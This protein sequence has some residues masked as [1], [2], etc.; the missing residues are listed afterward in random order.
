M[1]ESFVF[2]LFDIHCYEKNK[3][4][5]YNNEN[6]YFSYFMIN[7]SPRERQSKTKK[8]CW[9]VRKGKIL[10]YDPSRNKNI[11]GQTKDF[12]I[13]YICLFI[14]R[15]IVAFCS[16]KKV[17]CWYVES[18]GWEAQCSTWFYVYFWSDTSLRDKRSDAFQKLCEI[19]IKKILF[20]FWLV[21][22][23]I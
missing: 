15:N 9:N 8:S 19:R 4:N 13:F 6:Q 20:K 11:Y 14:Y 21:A 5:H 23:F 3:S 10:S 17:S 16:S 1:R 22:W 2:A 7:T 18:S 12:V